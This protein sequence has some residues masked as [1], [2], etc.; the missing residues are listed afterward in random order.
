MARRMSRD[1]QLHAIADYFKKEIKK[2]D[3]LTEK[4]KKETAH[5]GLMEIGVIDADGN[6]AEPYRTLRESD[7]FIGIWNSALRILPVPIIQYP[8]FRPAAAT[9]IFTALAT[10][11]KKRV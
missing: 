10:Y 5:N 1:E 2:F 8:N 7:M 11:L 6:L 3:A 4:Q 9:Y